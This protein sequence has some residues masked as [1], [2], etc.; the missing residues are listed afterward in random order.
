MAALG[1]VRYFVYGD[2]E[3]D[4]EMWPKMTTTYEEADGPD[5][6][7]PAEADGFVMDHMSFMKRAQLKASEE[8]KAQQAAKPAADAGQ[9]ATAPAT[10]PLVQPK[11]KRPADEGQK[12]LTEAGLKLTK[13]PKRASP[14]GDAGTL[15]VPYGDEG[16]SNADALVDLTSGP[17]S[18]AVSNLPPAAAATRMKG[19]G[20]ELVKGTYK[21]EVEYPVKGGLFNEIVDGH[22]VISQAIP[23][24]DRAYLKKLG[25]V[26]MYDGGID[27]IIQACIALGEHARRFDEWRLQKAQQEESLKKLIHDNAEAV[28]QMAQL[29][30]GLQQARAEAERAAKERVEMEKAAAEAAKKALEDAEAAKAEVAAAAVPAFMTEGWKAEGHKDW[31]AS[32]MENSAEGWVKGPVAMWLARKGEDYYAGG[33]FFTQ[34][35]IYRRLARHLKIEPTAFDPAAYGLPPPPA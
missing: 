1:F 18:T 35:L 29:E 5:L 32:V 14:A 19:S 28:R 15:T 34:A 2:K 17:P 4:V 11:K 13:K 25:N 10:K 31:V 21:L 8:L 22:E 6:G 24:E 3:D 12:K 27:H 9:P 16:S 33:D 26:K 30:R 7:V 20:R 23:D